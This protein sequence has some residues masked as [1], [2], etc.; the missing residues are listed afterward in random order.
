MAERL[1]KVIENH[2]FNEVG[3]I[4]ASFGVTGYVPEDTV[5]TILVRA[6][7]RL[8]SSKENGRN[9]VSGRTFFDI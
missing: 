9:H 2:N 8:Y 6:D 4:T 7:K 1:R 3:N 5:N